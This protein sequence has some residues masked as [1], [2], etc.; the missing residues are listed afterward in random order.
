MVRVLGIVYNLYCIDYGNRYIIVFEGY[1]LKLHNF[2]LEVTSSLNFT[3]RLDRGGY[4]Y[5]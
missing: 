2:S 1:I 4:L 5:K 3:R